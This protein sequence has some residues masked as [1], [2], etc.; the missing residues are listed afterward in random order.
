MAGP[1]TELG[2]DRSG[3]G[4]NFTVA[5]TLGSDQMVD[6]PTNNFCT[7]NPND[8]STGQ[9]LSEGNLK[10][11]LPDN[12]TSIASMM[13][14]S[15]KWYFEVHQV[16]IGGVGII[17]SL[18]AMA[19]RGSSNNNGY[20]TYYNFSNFHGTI[21]YAS[22][23]DTT[24]SSGSNGD[25]V[26]CA[27]DLD[28]NKIYWHVNG[29]YISTSGGQQNPTNASNPIAI[30]QV[31]APEHNFAPAFGAYST[32]PAFIVNFGQ[33]SSFAGTKTAQGNQDS[34][35][36]G[37]FYY[38]PPTGFLA[39]C[40]QN[41]PAATVTPT[42]HF[43][44]V[45]YTG[46][47]S[48]N[49]I[50]GVGFQ[51]DFVWTKNR[52]ETYFHTLYDAIRGTGTSKA[53]HSND[54]ASEG[55]HS[56]HNNLVSFDTNGFTLGATSSTN[57]MNYDD[58]IYASWNWKAASTASGTTTGSGTG[59]SYSA[60]YNTDA[61]FSIVNFAGNGTSGHTI[62]H[63]LSKAPEMIFLKN[64]GTTYNWTV[65]NERLTSL[66]AVFLNL[67]SAST[68]TDD[69]ADTAATSS[70][71]SVGSG[72]ATN[73]NNANH[74][75]YCWHSVDGYS[76]I[77]SYEATGNAGVGGKGNYIHTGFRPA[78]VIAKAIDY[79]ND[80]TGWIMY[81]NKRDGWNQGT[82]GNGGN[83]YLFAN[84]TD[85]EANLTIINFFSNGF[86]FRDD[87]HNSNNQLTYIYM[88]FAEI[89]FKYSNAI[90]Q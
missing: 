50:T 4:N 66:N 65:Y 38:T 18:A 15:G 42:E 31:D 9:T 62:P 81:D 41:L 30:S 11:V 57:V 16:N 23:T 7:L 51:P 52:E 27:F 46:N 88:A 86:Q 82:E 24:P 21:Y 36:I 64:N 77:G 8:P 74:I 26:G 43:K 37:D 14:S 19:G 55:T 89:P 73:Q 56:A 13:V 72:G 67:S 20:G 80:Y 33:D 53:I 29:T 54:T 45:L 61:G 76:R 39:L 1:A 28:N 3:N 75:A 63:Q 85:A 68:A 44:T 70:V 5:G 59:K 35:G 2:L 32:N 25:I 84:V 71:F 60:R 47:A 22:S 49:A 78:F 12:K 48:T 6:T 34:G 83:K 40:T 69:W 79:T 17:N 58:H 90:S 87:Y 10:T